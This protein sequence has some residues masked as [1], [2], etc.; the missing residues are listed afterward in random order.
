[1]VR[2]A[3]ERIERKKQEVIDRI[4]KDDERQRKIDAKK[5]HDDKWLKN[6]EL[7]LVVISRKLAMINIS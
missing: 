4:A 7:R 6:I 1:M 3:K 2:E 5:H